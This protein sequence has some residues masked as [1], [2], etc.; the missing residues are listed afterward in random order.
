MQE[1]VEPCDDAL[2]ML[3]LLRGLFSFCA[4]DRTTAAAGFAHRFC[5]VSVPTAAATTAE[6]V[7][8]AAPAP[9]AMVAMDPS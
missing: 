9:E 6:A 5:A 3:D 4:S 8:A 2:G 1:I 7:A